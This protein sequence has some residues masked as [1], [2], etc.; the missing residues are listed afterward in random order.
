[1]KG[2]RDSALSGTGQQPHHPEIIK[3]GD[4]ASYSVYASACFC[5]LEA[6][7]PYSICLIPVIGH[8]AVEEAF[9][10]QDGRGVASIQF[11]SIQDVVAQLNLA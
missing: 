6:L 5:W 4:C 3:R 10:C 9:F 1:M 7:V 8:W 11:N 2:V